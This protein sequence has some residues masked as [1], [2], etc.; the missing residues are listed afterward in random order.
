VPK[1]FL[2]DSIRVLCIPM[3]YYALSMRFLRNSYIGCGPVLLKHTPFSAGILACCARKKISRKVTEA[4]RS[5]AT[6]K[7]SDE[8]TE[9]G[10]WI[11]I[12]SATGSF[13]PVPSAAAKSFFH[14][15]GVVLV[16]GNADPFQT[17]PDCQEL[18]R[19]QSV[20][21]M[22]SNNTLR[23]LT[24]KVRQGPES[25]RRSTSQPKHAP[26]RPVPEWFLSGS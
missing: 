12:D 26:K 24:R 17:C 10:C 19:R 5:L 18:S 20:R 4:I 21:N 8:R 9:V 25:A 11:S 15:F 13:S 14:V 7:A 16:R 22:L 6:T 23:Q 1:Q 3:R 2:C